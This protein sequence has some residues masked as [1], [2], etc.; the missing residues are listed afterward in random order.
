MASN[1]ELRKESRGTD[2]SSE[3][4]VGL[5]LSGGGFR[6]SFFHLGVL[7]RL[8]EVDAL[9]DVQVLST[10]SGGS[11]VGAHY[12]LEVQRLLESKPDQ[13][14]TRD[15]YVDIVRRVQEEFLKGVQTNIR[16]TALASFTDNLRMVFTKH[17]SRSHRLGELYEKCIYAH[18]ADGHPEGQPRTMPDLIIKP[19][20][21]PDKANFDP[22][23]SNR[24]RRSKVPVLLIN[25]TS[26]NSGHNWH[27]TA[28]R[29]GEPPGLLR[30]AEVDV[31]QR[32][33]RVD[34]EQ[35]PESLRHYRLGYAVA[36][37]ACVPGL[38][39][40]LA[41]TGLYPNHTVRLVDGGVHDNQGVAGLLDEDC[42]VILCSD[43]SGQMDDLAQP[44]DTTIESLSRSSA[45]ISDRVREAQYQDLA[46]QLDTGKLEGL[47]F[48]HAKQHLGG[49]PLDW[50]GCVDPTR[51]APEGNLTSYG[52]DKDLQR[53]IAG[54]R[55]DLDS[56]TEVEAYA[57]MLSGYLI[58]E[59]EL[60]EPKERD[61][62]TPGAGAWNEY[63]VSAPRRDWPFL[64]LESLCKLGP[65]S[66]HPGRQ[67][68][69]KQ[70]QVGRH[71]FLK[72]W[73]FDPLLQYAKRGAVGLVALA[74]LLAWLLWDSPVFGPRFTWGVVIVFLA[75]ALFPAVAPNL[76]PILKWLEP[77][78]A[79]RG[80]GRKALVAVF[81]YLGT[82]LHLKVF[83]PK[84]LER[85]RLQRLLDLK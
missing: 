59:Y 17:Y 61:Q 48:V 4:K 54:L 66:P 71:G 36:A 53:K 2:S 42:T 33:R 85:G 57:L 25:A 22:K 21:D 32:Y 35:A 56:F 6:A 78:K 80:Y 69:G 9:R 51:S 63:D 23:L 10:V 27:F 44:A 77:G 16:T 28:R 62:G 26:L 45:V 39:E 60:R 18:V 41:I 46:G 72:V 76:A 7:A 84:F 68:L 34:Y 20:G 58:S 37:S 81:G 8:A 79:V 83:D 15:D 74:V 50:V 70:L 3:R 75:V 14:I 1:V 13:A 73:H 43:A 12:Y 64:K 67:D 55:T 11:I 82:N 38:F 29:M 19:E 52:I 49:P 65:D 47:F 30:D 31:N 40:P 24:N 5:G